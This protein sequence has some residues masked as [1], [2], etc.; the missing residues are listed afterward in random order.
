[1]A[2][3]FSVLQTLCLWTINPRV[4]LAAYLQACADR[5]GAAP[6]TREDFLPWKMSEQKRQQW[7]LQKEKEAEDSS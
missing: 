5:G 3:L 2:M 1:M 7:S 6:A 4:W